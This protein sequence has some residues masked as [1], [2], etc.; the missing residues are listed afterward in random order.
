MPT[1]GRGRIDNRETW[2]I[3]HYFFSFDNEL[4]TNPENH[5]IILQSQN[6][7]VHNMEHSQFLTL[8]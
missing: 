2:I 3:Q 7:T 4:R 5:I 8:R 1:D 6:N